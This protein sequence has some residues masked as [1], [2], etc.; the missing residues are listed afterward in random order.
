MMIGDVAS[1]V[2]THTDHP[3]SATATKVVTYGGVTD[4]VICRKFREIG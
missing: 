4:V 2:C 1:H 3:R